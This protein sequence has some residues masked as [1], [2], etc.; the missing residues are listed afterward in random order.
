MIPTVAFA[1]KQGIDAQKLE[2]RVGLPLCALNTWEERVADD[3]LPRIWALI[4]EETSDAAPPPTLEMARTAPI[5]FF[6]HLGDLT[7]VAPD[8][9]TILRALAQNSGLISDRALVEL[10]VSGAA[11]TLRAWHPLEPLYGGRVHELCVAMISRLITHIFG[12]EVR[13][14]EVRFG[15]DRQGNQEH[16]DRFF[17]STVR[18]DPSAGGGAT[19]VFDRSL[20]QRPNPG[21][22]QVAA[23][24]MEGFITEL[25]AQQIRDGYPRELWRLR[26]AISATLQD[27]QSLRAPDIAKRAG[28][29]LRSTQ[30]LAEQF[31]ITLRQLV[32]EVRLERAK[33]LMTVNPSASIDD[34]G[35]QLGF[36][37]PSGFRRAFKNWSGESLGTF[38]KRLR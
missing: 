31:G 10:H 2:E 14:A 21:A 9:G 25:Q 23:R 22:N 8:L 33:A 35:R 1:L 27:G 12:D 16:F 19:M 20:L 15:F 28:M 32:D 18:F 13:A 26:G 7:R 30:R 24:F 3:V 17:G 5:S 11:A 38:R 34:V 4:A 29:S 37:D 36:S 6:G